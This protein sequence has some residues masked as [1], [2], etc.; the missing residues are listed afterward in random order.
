MIKEIFFIS[1]LVGIALAFPNPEE[2]KSISDINTNVRDSVQSP[3]GESLETA[4]QRWGGRG[5]KQGGGGWH[6]GGGG[7]HNGGGGG[8]KKGGGY[9]K[10]G[11]GGG[12]RTGG[13]GRK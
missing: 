3:V 2:H 11:G 13:W 1:F 10:G 7:W 8:W 4:E 6:N 12:W 9:Y 5:W